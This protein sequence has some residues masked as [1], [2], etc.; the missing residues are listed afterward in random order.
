ML[1]AALRGADTDLGDLAVTTVRLR[2]GDVLI[3]KGTDAA[4]PEALAQKTR[5]QR[6]GVTAG[7]RDR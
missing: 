4:L 5:D 3:L 7:S 1:L 6:I 2:P